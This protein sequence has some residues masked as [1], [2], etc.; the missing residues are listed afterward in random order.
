VLIALIGMTL[1][2]QINPEKTVDNQETKP[3][4]LDADLA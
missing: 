4:G 3:A 1:W 2:S